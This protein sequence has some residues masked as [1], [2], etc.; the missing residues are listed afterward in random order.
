VKM[1][2]KVGLILLVAVVVAEQEEVAEGTE[3]R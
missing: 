3:V 2:L 1:A